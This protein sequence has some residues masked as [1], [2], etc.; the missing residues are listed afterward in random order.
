MPTTAEQAL[1]AVRAAVAS[2]AGAAL[3]TVRVGNSDPVRGA[4]S[5]YV[6]TTITDL[7]VTYTTSTG[8]IDATPLVLTQ[9]REALYQVM[10]YGQTT[11]AK[12]QALCAHLLS[13]RSSVAITFK[14]A[15]CSTIRITGPRDMSAYYQTGTEPRYALDLT[16][17]Y[18]L[19]VTTA[20]ALEAIEAI[21]ANVATVDG[22]DIDPAVIVTE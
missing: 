8:G 13:P 16:I 14:A 18:V 9:T 5:Y 15:G 20:A 3:T 1:Q 6:V 21:E 11:L 4:S 19:E 10:G 22:I 7:P 2:A 12:L 17:Q